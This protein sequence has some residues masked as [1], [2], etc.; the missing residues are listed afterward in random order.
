M[1][2]SVLVRKPAQPVALASQA[3]G[4]FSCDC[5]LKSDEA[6]TMPQPVHPRGALLRDGTRASPCNSLLHSSIGQTPQTPKSGKT[7]KEK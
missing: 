3:Y 7:Q 1:R 2:F 5:P 6:L 4:R